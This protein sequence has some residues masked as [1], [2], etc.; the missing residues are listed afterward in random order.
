LSEIEGFGQ[1]KGVIYV[2]YQISDCKDRQ[3]AEK[4]EPM[5]RKRSSEEILGGKV[6][7]FS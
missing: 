2:I 1:E 6:D 3:K 4:I 5:T 7:I